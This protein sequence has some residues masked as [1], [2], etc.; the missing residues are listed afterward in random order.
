MKTSA[1]L[2][3][4]AAIALCGALAVPASAGAPKTATVTL[5]DISF[6]RATVKIA[7][8]GT[9]MWVWK[10]GP[11]PHNVTFAHRHSGTKKTGTYKMTFAKAGTY[12]YHCTLHPGMDGK[13]VVS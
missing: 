5:K 2:A 7:R 3:A 13:V 12:K 11:S 9:V 8:G 4:L 6:K 1:A 10:D